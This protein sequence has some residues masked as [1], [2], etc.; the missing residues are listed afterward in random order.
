MLPQVLASGL[1]AGSIY[2][3]MALALVITYKT[4]EVPNFAQGD[5]AMVSAFIAYMFLTDFETG[6]IFA[7]GVALVFAFLL[8]VGFE[9][10]LL[11]RMRKPTHLNLIIMT[12]GFTLA[13]FG[14]AGWKWGADQRHFPFPISANEVIRFGSV[15]ISTLSVATILIAG[16]LMLL[17]FV[18]FRF[19][20]LGVAMQ[21]TQQDPIAAR[22]NGVPA[23]AVV[24]LTFGI[25]SVIGTVAALLT[26]PLITLDPTLMWDAL[27]K[28]FAAAVLGGL[29]TPVGA[30]LGG[31]LLGVIEN[32]FG[33]YVSVEFKS[34]VAFLIIVIVLWFK[35]SGLFGRHHERKV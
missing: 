12:L 23:R 35:P 11:R 8:G 24:G 22:I 9:G 31:Y 5:M 1:S 17:V 14:F 27:L 20:K 2:A 16:I 10:L 3:L 15:S 13:L 29:N 7:F 25:S 32:L 26:A 6:F 34:V 18:F 30:V 33:A 19:T 4:T 28:G 21:A